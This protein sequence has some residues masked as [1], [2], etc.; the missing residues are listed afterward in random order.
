MADMLHL[1]LV[2]P[3]RKLFDIETPWVIIPG[4][5][6][7]LGIL[8]QHVPLLTTIDSGVLRWSRDGKEQRVAVHYGYAQVSGDRVT[9]LVEMA[10]RR[11]DIDKARLAAAAERARKELRA[12]PDEKGEETRQKKYEAKLARAMVRESIL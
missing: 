9:V 3:Q 6:G 1:E 10:E 12:R 5:S 4:S 2:T 7:E 8:P 11:E